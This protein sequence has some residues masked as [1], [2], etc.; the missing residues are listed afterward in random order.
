MKKDYGWRSGRNTPL[1]LAGPATIEGTKFY[2]SLK[3]YNAGD[4][5]S[6]GQAEQQ[7][8]MRTQDIALAI[9]W[10][11]SLS[12][13]LKGSEPGRFGFARIPGNVSMIG[14]GTYFINK[15]SKHLESAAQYVLESM[16]YESQVQLMLRGLCSARESVYRDARLKGIPYLPAVHDSLVSGAYM[17]ESGPESALVRDTIEKYVQQIWRSQIS[18]EAGLQKAQ[19]EIEK[20]RSAYYR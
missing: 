13:L 18:V 10:S 6:T 11:D 5:L 17:L 12:P 16:S 14:G 2:V 7:E 4:F 9:M 19:E 8:R 20:G 1:I 3:P 15:N